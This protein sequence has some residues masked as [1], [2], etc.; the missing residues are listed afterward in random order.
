MHLDPERHCFLTFSQARMVHSICHA[1]AS[2]HGRNVA[3]LS[4]CALPRS[5]PSRDFAC[6]GAAGEKIWRLIPFPFFFQPSFLSK[7]DR[8]FP[9]VCGGV[10]ERGM[11]GKN[12]E[13]TPRFIV[14]SCAFWLYFSYCRRT[15]R[16]DGWEAQGVL[17]RP[18]FTL[19]TA[20]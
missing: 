14:R 6:T 4:V 12:K 9:S 19:P 8:H 13:G 16:G 2:V 3:P 10:P 1:G 17:E 11:P 18:P 15:Q 20:R 7:T 5:W